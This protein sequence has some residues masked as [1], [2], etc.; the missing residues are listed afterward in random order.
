MLSR[1]IRR[2]AGR[3]DGRMM[4]KSYSGGFES[5]MASHSSQASNSTEAWTLSNA[6]QLH[7]SAILFATIRS[8][9]ATSEESSIP[10]DLEL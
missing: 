3:T 5:S 4:V 7:N 6:P 1:T 2:P 9:E 8:G 10:H